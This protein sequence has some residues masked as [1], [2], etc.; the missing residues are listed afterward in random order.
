MPAS[1]NA[2]KFGTRFGLP[3]ET[4]EDFTT[5]VAAGIAVVVVYSMVGEVCFSE[6][7]K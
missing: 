5:E 2:S 6:S 3:E 7:L 1:T 4:I